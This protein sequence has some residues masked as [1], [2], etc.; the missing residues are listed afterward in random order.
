ML[1]NF[2]AAKTKSIPR[3]ITSSARGYFSCNFARGL[4]LLKP[5]SVSGRRWRKLNPKNSFIKKLKILKSTKKI[6]ST[7]TGSK[8][9]VLDIVVVLF[10]RESEFE[11]TSLFT[12]F[13]FFR[14]NKFYVFCIIVLIYFFLKQVLDIVV[15]HS[16]IIFWITEFFIVNHLLKGTS[17]CKCDSHEN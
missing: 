12:I 13:F 3:Q 6:R 11:T 1:A 16:S 15:D 17:F 10:S 14:R 9:Q 4:Q 2:S 8:N 5:L 7:L